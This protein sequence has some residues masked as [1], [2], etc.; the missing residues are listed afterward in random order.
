M[1]ADSASSYSFYPV[2]L[3]N[4]YS[5]NLGLLAN[6]LASLLSLLGGVVDVLLHLSLVLLPLRVVDT[7]GGGNANLGAS[8]VISHNNSTLLPCRNRW[9]RRMGQLRHEGSG[10]A[11][12]FL[13]QELPC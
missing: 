8:A 2:S 9:A 10:Q 3:N 6:V 1:A 7:S 13:Q 11:R 4:D 12:A 5:T